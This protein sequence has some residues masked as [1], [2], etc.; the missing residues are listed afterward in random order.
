MEVMGAGDAEFFE[1]VFVVDA[2]ESDFGSGVEV[3][4]GAVEVKENMAVLHSF[5]FLLSSEF[6]FICFNCH[7]PLPFE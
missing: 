2:L 4:K 1:M 3:P 6:L 5:S 7:L